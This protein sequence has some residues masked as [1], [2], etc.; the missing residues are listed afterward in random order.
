M[1]A[2]QFASHSAR[3]RLPSGV[4]GLS[5]DSFQPPPALLVFGLP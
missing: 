4:N 2:F 3:R 1:R 5:G